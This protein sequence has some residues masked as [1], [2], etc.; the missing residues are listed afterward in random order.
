MGGQHHR[1]IQKGCYRFAGAINN[2]KILNDERQIS[3]KTNN[4]NRVQVESIVQV[5]YLSNG[6][7]YKF[8]LVD[9]E[10]KRNEIINGIQKINIRSIVAVSLKDKTV[11]DIVKIG[12]L[13]TFVE[14][15]EIKNT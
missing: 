13:D 12:D 9:S 4:N 7:L 6:H 10:I 11:G 1:N 14:I 8:H 2:H 3:L 15:L 5:K